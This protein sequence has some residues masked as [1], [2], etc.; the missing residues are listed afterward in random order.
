LIEKIG[1]DVGGVIIDK[2]N[3]G[4]DTSFM[5][6]NYLETTAVPQA[7]ESIKLLVERMSAQNVFIVSKCGQKVQNKTRHWL[8]HHDVF[9]KTGL[10]P[11]NIHFCLERPQKAPICERLGITHFVDD[12]YDVLCHMKTVPNRFMFCPNAQDIKRLAQEP[13]D[14][15][16]VQSWPEVCAKIF[17][18]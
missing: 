14:I 10:L 2:V 6:D 18:I 5:W 1:I 12:R 13:M 3:D 11:E 7:I 15:L 17:A 9:G 16:V 8:S 4:T